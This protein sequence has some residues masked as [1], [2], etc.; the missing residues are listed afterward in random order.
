MERLANFSDEMAEEWC[1][2]LGWKTN[3]LNEVVES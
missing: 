3:G 1:I 2:E